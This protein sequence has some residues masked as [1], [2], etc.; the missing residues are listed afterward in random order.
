M[1]KR[2][3]NSKQLF[4]EMT[5]HACRLHGSPGLA[6][7]ETSLPCYRLFPMRWKSTGS[8]YVLMLQALMNDYAFDNR[9]NLQIRELYDSGNSARAC[10][11]VHLSSNWRSNRAPWPYISQ[12]TSEH[13]SKESNANSANLAL[14]CTSPAHKVAAH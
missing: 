10:L 5:L 12:F 4:H 2:A 8:F 9:S 6:K 13:R 11:H 1:T 3:S 14:L 7:T